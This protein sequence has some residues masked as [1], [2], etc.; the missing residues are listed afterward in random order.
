MTLR[1]D[2]ESYIKHGGPRNLNDLLEAC[3]KEGSLEG[4]M[5]ITRMFEDMYGGITFNLE[6]KGPP[7][8]ELACW[9]ERG[10]DQLVE[11]TLKSPKSKNLSLCLEIL[12]HI[13]S[14]YD[15]RVAPFSCDEPRRAKLHTLLQTNP[16]LHAYARSKLLAFVLAID[17]EDELLDI[18]AQ[19][20]NRT[21][22]SGTKPARELFAAL[23]TRW[24]TIGEPLLL[25]YESL[26]ASRADDEPAFQRFF[27]EHP[28][29]LDPMAAEIWPQ[30]DLH[31]AQQPDFVIRRF[32]NSYVVVEIETPGKQLVTSN[33][34]I[35]SWVTHA[36]AQA[37][38]YRR[39]IERLPA[40]QMHFPYLDQVLC[41][42]VVGL[43]ELAASICRPHP[44][45]IR[46]PQAR[47]RWQDCGPRHI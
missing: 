14:G 27:T 44:Q 35:S 3:T 7:A 8:W 43:E 1:D 32:D 28:Q 37:T 31:G 11:A 33:N 46:L 41:F 29:I 47:E 22:F 30:P 38:E 12:T 21:A 5:C 42:V 10:L 4:L 2:V 6:L 25:G 36:A 34:Q 24:L 18:V 20:F 17:D 19:G 26:I 39:F 9:G 15:F 40:V 16:A 13:A 23:S 45:T